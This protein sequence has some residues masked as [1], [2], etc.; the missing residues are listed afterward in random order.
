MTTTLII[1]E[2]FDA[3]RRI[4][5]ILSGGTSKQKRSQGLNYIE[6]SDK[7]DRT[8]MVPLSG[9]IV[10]LDFQE[11]FRDWSK[12]DLSR[13][14]FS[15]LITK[16]KNKTAHETLTRMAQEADR[17][18]V[19]TDYDREGE[20]I[21]QE[22]L[23]IIGVDADSDKISRAKFSSL[24]APEIKN[25]FADLI[26]VD[27]DIA[28][29]A[30]AREEIDLIWGSVLTRFFSVAA[31]RLGTNFLSIGRV[32]TPTLALIVRREEE[33]HNF[34]PEKY[35]RI[36]ATFFK[37]EEFQGELESGPVKS[38]EEAE[39]ILDAINGKDGNVIRFT[40]ENVPIK[41]PPPFNTT[42]F[43]REVSKIGIS[44]ARAMRIAESL[45][46][47]GLIS[48]PRTDNMVYNRTLPLKGIVEKLSKSPFSKEA[49]MV[50]DQE[51]IIPSRGKVEA[52]DHP[53]IYP[54]S[55]PGNRALKGE[56]MRVY[57]L[58]V[59]RFLAT[60]Y[61]QGL[62]ERKEASIDI[63]GRSFI[64]RGRKVLDPGWLEIYPYR[65]IYENFHPDL[66]EGETVKV[67]SV[68]PLEETTKPPPRYDMGNILKTMEELKLGTK[69]TRHDILEK[70]QARGFIEGNPIIPTGLGIA[71][72]DA[73]TTVKSTIS[74]P[75][76][77]AHLED[78][79]DGIAN[80]RKTR[81]TVV[82]ESREMLLVVLKDLDGNREKVKEIINKGLTKG[83]KIGTCPEHNTDVM[84]L[85]DRERVRFWCVTEGCQIK[86][87]MFINGKVT[88]TE[89][90][91]P[92]CEKPIV[93]I[94][95]RGQSPEERC[96]DPKCKYNL[97]R[98]EL[99]VCPSDGGKLI[100][101][102]SRYGKRFVGCANYPACTV[103]YPLP[104]MGYLTITGETCEF[105]KAPLLISTRGNR[106]WKFCPK[107]DCEFNHK[108]KK[109]ASEKKVKPVKVEKKGKKTVK[110]KKTRKVKTNEKTAT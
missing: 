5:Y 93:R 16:V 1:A 82:N 59:R 89:K 88:S 87:D 20:L 74:E 39:E 105:C 10:E 2:K 28:D 84:L 38:K 14:I 56:Y 30:A 25:S 11:E 53:P 4:S 47:S 90:K 19:A 24:T 41:K 50:L 85:K 22:A 92:I 46:T 55:A 106:K 86:Y 83:E 68:N 107:M 65:R 66:A 3:A 49:Q 94:I 64:T 18:I 91:C 69:S 37:D 72:I 21:G 110:R 99:G 63:G 44:P 42:E 57:E 103:T 73:V 102:Q 76:M 77:T 45:Y 7:D 100:I 34:V 109:K 6:Y 43:L 27:R 29:S 13:M 52:T 95:R 15:E 17:I 78:D 9:H 26:K 40:M 35:W 33:I 58:I 31:R 48:Y 62:E 96:V 67:I 61:R 97:Q 54:V 108:G 98:Q 80:R 75:E 79:M 104:Q 32:Q 60:L 51:K 71:L 101:R 36:V 12:A 8:V 23:N 81:D 70:L